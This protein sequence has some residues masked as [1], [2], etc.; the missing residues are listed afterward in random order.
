MITTVGRLFGFFAHF[1]T[2]KVGNIQIRK[3]QPG[4]TV[5]GILDSELLYLTIKIVKELRELCVLIKD[6]EYLNK[7]THCEKE[8]NVVL[9]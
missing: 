4:D 9:K 8:P 1:S 7:K 3:W 5:L 6:H 2:T